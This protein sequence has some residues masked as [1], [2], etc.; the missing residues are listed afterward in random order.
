MAS[1]FEAEVGRLMMQFNTPGV[2][3]ELS[4]RGKR[5]A[6]YMGRLT[7][8]GSLPVTKKTRF[9]TICMIKALIAI[10]ILMLAEKGEINLD[11]AVADYLPELGKGPKAKGHFLKIRH[12]LSHTGGFRSFTV[13]RLMP[14]AHE[15]W[16]NCV[17]LMHETDQLF[18][19]GTV[20]DDDHMSHIILGQV[21]T[22]LKGKH[23]LEVICEDILAP[24]GI[25]PGNRTEDA[26][27]P[28][29][30]ASRHKWNGPEK[31]GRWNRM[32]IQS[33]TPRSA[34]FHI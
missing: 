18:E 27:Q 4:S 17:D 12:L 26:G 5:H 7:V 2:A 34:P 21:L 11:A 6:A 10:E 1:E 25:N 9:A 15:S 19:P 23:F 13:Q 28:E 8:G 16:Q 24:L 29:I 32:P 30:Y 33:P 31:N 22:T 20:F 3:V 14:L